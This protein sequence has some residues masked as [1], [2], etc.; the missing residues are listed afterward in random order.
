LVQLNNPALINRLGL[1]DHIDEFG[2]LF[3][4]QTIFHFNDANP[5]LTLVNL[6]RADTPSEEPFMATQLALSRRCFRRAFGGGSAEFLRVFTSYSSVLQLF[7]LP[8]HSFFAPLYKSKTNIMAANILNSLF[9]ELFE[10]MN[11]EH[12]QQL[13]LFAQLCFSEPILPPSL[14]IQLMT[15]S[16]NAH[17]VLENVFDLN[18]TTP[19][20]LLDTKFAKLWRLAYGVIPYLTR[21]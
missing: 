9:T 10:A 4:P 12:D 11:I 6:P 19:D 5:L 8:R 21:Y 20:C 14:P 16:I 15:A 17:V 2:R 18:G 1:I 3:I 7:I 13:Q